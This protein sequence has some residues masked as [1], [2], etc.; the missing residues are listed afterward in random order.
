MTAARKIVQEK[1]LPLI[2]KVEEKKGIEKI[3]TNPPLAEEF[4]LVKLNKVLQ[5]IIANYKE[6]HKNLEVTVLKQPVELSG[7]TITFKLNGEIQ[8]DIFYKIKPE[9][10]QLLRRKL[11]N[12]SIHLE[13]VIA[14]EATDEK[15]KLYTSSDKLRYLKEKSP[16]LTE[17]QRRFGLET[18]F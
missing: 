7:E 4:D 11:N 10:F 14:E 8:Q 6:Q 12:Y 3:S 18:D 2:P 13:S 15:K 5:D 16:A 17:L 9:V 1:P